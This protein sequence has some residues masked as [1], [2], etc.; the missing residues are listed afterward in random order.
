VSIGTA[1]WGVLPAVL[2]F[3]PLAVMLGRDGFRAAV[4]GVRLPRAT[5]TLAGALIAGGTL[6]FKYFPD[7]AAQ[8]SPKEA[9]ES[10]ARLSHGG[11]PLALL[12]VRSRSAAY[13]GGGEAPSFTDANQAFSWLTDAKDGRRW[14]LLKADDL[15]R[16][17]ALYRGLYEK[18]LPVLD[19]RSSQILLASNQLGDHANENALGKLVL[20]EPPSPVH[21]VD[22]TF[23]DQLTTIGWDVTDTDGKRVDSVVPS[24][25]YRLRTYYRVLKPMQQTWKLFV[26]IDGFQRRFNGDHNVLDG[27]YGMNFWRPGDVVVDDFE[28]ALE[29]NF[30]PGAYTLFYGFFTGDTRFKVTKGPAQ[31]NRIIAGPIEVR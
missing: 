11:E 13:Y 30:T 17:N 15:P 27:K 16:L 29:P 3:V 12:S 23:E 20:D 1:A 10:Y 28:F 31:D 5:F 9:F 19:G 14:L 21:R 24:K 25:T 2:A 22:A 8:L 7:V 6:S 18:N 26:H 4:A